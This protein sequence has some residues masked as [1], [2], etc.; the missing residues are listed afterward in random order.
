MIDTS[1]VIWERQ[2]A[3]SEKKVVGCDPQMR[4]KKKLKLFEGWSHKVLYVASK[5]SAT[6]LKN[7]Q[8]IECLVQIAIYEIEEFDS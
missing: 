7:Q 3:A 1:I 6:K 4:K 2:R 5:S 8:Q